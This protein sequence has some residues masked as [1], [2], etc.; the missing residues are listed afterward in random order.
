MNRTT[1]KAGGLY[2]RQR[3]EGVLEMRKMRVPLEGGNMFAHGW[4]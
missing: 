4:H 3:R 2:L 1:E